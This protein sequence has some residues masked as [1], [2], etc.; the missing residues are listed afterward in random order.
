[1]ARTLFRLR[2]RD[3]ATGG[4]QVTCVLAPREYSA[5]IW[6]VITVGVVTWDWILCRRDHSTYGGGALGHNTHYMHDWDRASWPRFLGL[7]GQ[8]SLGPAFLFST[9]YP[10]GLVFTGAAWSLPFLICGRREEG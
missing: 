10:L 5:W 4:D 9:R 1:M 3:P 8:D 2:D 7:E 6:R